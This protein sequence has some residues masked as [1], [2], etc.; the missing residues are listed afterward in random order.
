MHY[1]IIFL[2]ALESRIIKK[3]KGTYIMRNKTLGQSI[4]PIKNGKYGISFYYYDINGRKQ[5]KAFTDKDKDA[6][7]Q[8]YKHPIQIELEERAKEVG[9]HGGMDY[10]MDSRLVYCLLNG[11]PLD[12]D[13]YDAAEWS[14]L[15]ELTR[16]SLE[17]NSAPVEVPDFTRGAWNKLKGYHHYMEGE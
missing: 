5:R 16:I 15:G 14:S 1:C 8:K 6:L 12:Q 9:G 7:L 13:V 11:L 4:Y 2:S 3:E 17:N 10:I